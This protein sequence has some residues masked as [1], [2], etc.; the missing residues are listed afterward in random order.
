MQDRRLNLCL[1]ATV[2]FRRNGSAAEIGKGFS[3]VHHCLAVK[4][5]YL[6]RNDNHNPEMNNP[7]AKV[8]QMIKVCP[9]NLQIVRRAW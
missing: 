7:T 1:M 2:I 9:F 8:R 5:L 3:S 6:S 4:D